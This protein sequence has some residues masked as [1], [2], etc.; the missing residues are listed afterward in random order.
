MGNQGL[1]GRNA[2][3]DGLFKRRPDSP[4]FW[5]NVIL[6]NLLDAGAIHSHKEELNLNP[7]VEWPNSW[8]VLE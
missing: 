7:A 1:N 5:D 6:D 2:G 4:V 3:T 8:K